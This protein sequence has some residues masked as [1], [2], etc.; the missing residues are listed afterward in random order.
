MVR[1]PT[2]SC[3]TVLSPRSILVPLSEEDTQLLFLADWSEFRGTDH[4]CFL[5]CNFSFLEPQFL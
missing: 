5:S 3:P 4:P 1:A 2:P